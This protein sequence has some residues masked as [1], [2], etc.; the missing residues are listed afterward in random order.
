[1]RAFSTKARVSETN[2]CLYETSVISDVIS[3]A[4]KLVSQEF[5]R[6]NKSLSNKEY[7]EWFA[8]TLGENVGLMH[9]NGWY[10]C[11]LGSH[12]ITLDCRIVDLDSIT[13]LSREI[14][15]CDD[16]NGAK[17]T[18]DY[19]MESMGLDETGFFKELFQKSY[20]AVF[21]PEEREK[22][23]ARKKKEKA[24]EEE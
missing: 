20:D 10:H 4:K 5:G 9:R 17:S 23:F 19:L 11:F 12:N 7:L 16:I 1:M 22:Y 15:Q 6:G 21:P 2:R 3:D 18:L 24:Q 13:E 8:K 14:D